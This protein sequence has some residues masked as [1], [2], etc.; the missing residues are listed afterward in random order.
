MTDP[1]Y[2][3]LKIYLFG[4]IEAFWEEKPIPLP[5]SE[6]RLLAY[7]LLHIASDLTSTALARHLYPDAVSD[8]GSSARRPRIGLYNAIQQ[9]GNLPP[10]SG[11]PSDTPLMDI[12]KE[13]WVDVWRFD[14]LVKSKKPEDLREAISLY[15]GPLLQELRRKSDKDDA[16]ANPL[17]VNRDESCDLAYERLFDATIASEDYNEALV[18]LNR[19]RAV[20][21]RVFGNENSD[22]WNAA[23]VRVNNRRLEQ[24]GQKIQ[25][26]GVAVS[27]PES[28]QPE[29]VS[30]SSSFSLLDLEGKSQMASESPLKI[31]GNTSDEPSDTPSIETPPNRKPTSEEREALI[32]L[33]TEFHYS[34]VNMMILVLGAGKHIQDNPTPFDKA[35]ALVAWAETKKGCGFDALKSHVESHIQPK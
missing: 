28:G 25:K 22:R 9:T 30:S 12:L 1:T 21:T 8:P 2:N 24:L 14:T 4:D 11:A 23:K 33:L 27:K 32:E 20:N 17:V 6:Q 18:L 35:N 26:P 5:A 16:W 3:G 29:T 19:W 13:A 31:I 10:L 7:M 15:R 34:E